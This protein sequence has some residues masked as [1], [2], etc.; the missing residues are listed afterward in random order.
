MQLGGKYQVLFHNAPQYWIRA[1]D[2]TPFFWNEKDGQKTSV[3][4]KTISLD[5]LWKANIVNA[6]LNSSLFYIWFISL[7]DCRHLNLREIENFPISFKNVN[8]SVQKEFSELVPKLMKS[9]QASKKRKSTQYKTTGSV[10]YDDYP[11]LSKP[12]IDEIDRVLAKHYNFTEEE[13]D[14]I[15]NYDI[16]YRMG[17][18]LEGNED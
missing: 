13:L 6:I 8:S 1:T 14:Y 7:S 12:I 11:R 9:L 4:I 15:I 5:E 10:E 18:E 2:F 3:Q 17:K 16:K